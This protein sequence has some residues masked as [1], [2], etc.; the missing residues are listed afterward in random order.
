MLLQL[1]FV[2]S[3]CT[4]PSSLPA[5]KT[6]TEMNAY[7]TQIV[8]NCFGYMGDEVRN[9]KVD[10]SLP[11]TLGSH[12]C[13]DPNSDCGLIT[14]GSKV[15]ETSNPRLIIAALAHEVGHV[16][17]RH[18]P[19]IMEKTTFESREYLADLLIAET[20]PEGACIAEEYVGWLLK[21][22]RG[23][24]RDLD[25][26]RISFSARSSSLQATCLVQKRFLRGK[27]K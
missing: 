17:I 8:V 5:G 1:I 4:I 15:M 22:P 23:S 13:D 21:L 25:L 7:L 27:P 2:A 19:T 3:T 24:I 16:K 14:P 12:G 26:A 18:D 20:L 10:I 9:I 11:Y 6:A